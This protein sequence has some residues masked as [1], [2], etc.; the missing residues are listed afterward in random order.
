MAM[1]SKG[2]KGEEYAILMVLV[3]NGLVFYH[4]FDKD[5]NNEVGAK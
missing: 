4:P 5:V 2:F 3:L 1:E